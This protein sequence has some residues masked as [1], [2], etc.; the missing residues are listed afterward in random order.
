M[1]LWYVSSDQLSPAQLGAARL[2]PEEHRLIVGAPGSGKTIVL[3]HRA[4]Y[5]LDRHNIKPDRLRIFAYTNALTDY[6]KS[7]LPLVPIREDCVTTFDSWCKEFHTSFI[8]RTLPRG[9]HGPDFD[10]LRSAVL[11][12]LRS[13]TS[14]KPLPPPRTADQIVRSMERQGIRG[15]QAEAA[16]RGLHEQFSNQKPVARPFFD[17]VLVDEGQDLNADAFEIIKLISPHVTVCMDHK[18][19]IYDG[20]CAEKDILSILGLRRRSVPLLEAHRCSPY[21]SRLAATLIEESQERQEFLN[22]IRTAQ[23]ERLTPL[24]FVAANTHDE[25][26]EV[27]NILRMRQHSGDR[28]AVLLPRN[29]QLFSMARVLTDAGLEIEV[30]A[31][32]GRNDF[33]AHDFTSDRPKLMTYHGAKGLTFDSVLLPRLA[34]SSFHSAS[35]SQLK[36]MLFVGMTRATRWLYLSGCEG[37]LLP[38]IAALIPM[39]T[40]GI[41]SVRYSEAIPSDL[42]GW[43]PQP[44]TIPAP[45]HEPI[46]PADK[47][48]DIL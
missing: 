12:K 21:I 48:L 37:N 25:K 6:I 13:A 27:A 46:V 5:L 32:P 31:A 24:L 45:A 19:Q 14:F 34:C 17:A 22:Q 15:P 38:S 36:R 4:G 3:L 44:R 16:C 8:D 30:P 43:P 2:G 35:D 28:I 47:L 39:E 40:E 20:R 41:L 26:A 42:F 33:P 11:A 18:Q 7:A 23:E 29:A 1:R 9:E 10:A